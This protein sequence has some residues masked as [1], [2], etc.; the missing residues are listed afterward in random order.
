MYIGVDLGGTKIKIGMVDEE[1][2]IVSSGLIDTDPSHDDKVIMKDMT[3][4]IERL[5]KQEGMQLQDIKSIGI[6]V[7]GLV[8]YQK[9]SII[10]CTNL[11]WYNVEAVNYLKEHFKIPVYI[12]NDATVAAYAESLFGSTKEAKDS[13]F[14]TIGTGIGGGIIINKQIIRGAH[15][16]GSE[17][18]HTVIG[19]NFYDC[20]CGRNGCFE[21][22]AS[23][24]AMIKYALHKM[25]TNAEVSSLQ[26]AYIEKGQLEAK[27]IFDHAAMGDALSI[28]TVDRTAKY[29]A[30]GI[31]NIYNILD[32]EII[33]IGGGVSKAGDSFFDLVRSKVKKMTLVDS[34]NIKYGE[35]VRA[36]LGNDAGIIGAAFLSKQA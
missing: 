32:P 29:L 28:E 3:V 12:E 34:D 24:T 8:D 16:A 35:I 9:G 14:L 27:D 31:A 25:N 30:I 2:Q 17:I 19:E 1:G 36:E 21:T 22:L 11:S 10:Y 18:G 6:G 33:A 20:N 13:V 15:G 26:R 23:A 4:E 5:I 7:P